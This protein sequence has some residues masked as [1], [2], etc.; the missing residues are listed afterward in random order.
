[1]RLN[2]ALRIVKNMEREHNKL[3]ILLDP[4]TNSDTANAINA[5]DKPLRELSKIVESHVVLDSGATY[6]VW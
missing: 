1:M 5:L 2:K 4:H 6:Y 3:W